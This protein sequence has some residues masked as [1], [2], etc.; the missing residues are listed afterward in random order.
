[1]AGSRSFR[2]AAA[3]TPTARSSVVTKGSR[4]KSSFVVARPL[5]EGGGGVKGLAS[6]KKNISFKKD[7][8]KYPN[9][10]GH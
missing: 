5:S 1:M 4:K 8:I 9:K 3:R 7:P 10:C 6:K 2:K